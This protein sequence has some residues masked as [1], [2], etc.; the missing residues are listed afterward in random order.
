[1]AVQYIFVYVQYDGQHPR[2]L[3]SALRACAQGREDEVE[4]PPH[5]CRFVKVTTKTTVP[6][7]LIRLSRV[8][9]ASDET[10]FLPCNASQALMTNQKFGRLCHVSHTGPSP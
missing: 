1:M 8:T 9:Q 6:F 10:K 5:N 7:R 2:P 4:H 3:A